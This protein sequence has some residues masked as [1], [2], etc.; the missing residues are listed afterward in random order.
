MNSVKTVLLMTLMACILMVIGGL[1]GGRS[2]VMI[3]FIFSLGMNFFSYWFSDKMVLKAYRAQPV[4]ETNRLYE[5]VDD[6]AKRADLPTPKVYVIATD[7]PNAFATGRNPSHAA[8]AVTEGL[9]DM[10]DEDEIR[11]VLAHEMSHILHRDILISTV[12]ACF[13]SAIAMIANMA[14]WAALFGGCGRSDDDS[15]SGSNIVTLLVTAIVAPI[16]ASLVQFAIS[17]TREY[18]ADDE[19]GRMI[20]DPLALARAL[21]KIDNYAHHAVLPGATPSTEHMCIVNPISGVKGAMTNLFSTHPSTADRIAKL[22]ALDK[23]LHGNRR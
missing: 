16:A 12:V 19:G 2:G 3:A 23:E 21:A 15:D 9:L 4:D 22:E 11:G 1:L 7:V 20:D 10:L 8:V 17:R 13:A 18:M 5:I 6:L 14:Q